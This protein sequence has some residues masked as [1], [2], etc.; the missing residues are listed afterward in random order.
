M[1]SNK[2]IVKDSILTKVRDENYRSLVGFFSEDILEFLFGDERGET[3]ASLVE[4]R[5]EGVANSH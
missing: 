5:T 3:S 1:R 2:S 4:S